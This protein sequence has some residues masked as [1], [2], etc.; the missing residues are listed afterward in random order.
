MHVKQ[1]VHEA[2]NIYK[3]QSVRITAKSIL[4]RYD[5]KNKRHSRA[6]VAPYAIER[7]KLLCGTDPKVK[8][9]VLYSSGRQ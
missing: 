7:P 8:A 6:G 2:I 1:F 9:A 4:E 3:K 5:A